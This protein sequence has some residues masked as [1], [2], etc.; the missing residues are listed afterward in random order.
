M[1]SRGPPPGLGTDLPWSVHPPGVSGDLQARRARRGPSDPY[2]V[3]GQAYLT[4]VGVPTL[5]QD[6]SPDQMSAMGSN[7]PPPGP[8]TG[9]LYSGRQVAEVEGATGL[10][11]KPRGG[12]KVPLTP[13]GNPNRRTHAGGVTSTRLISAPTW[14]TKC[15]NLDSVPGPEEVMSSRMMRKTAKMRR[16]SSD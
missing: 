6:W 11:G 9:L 2:L 10:R 1:G 16:K 15:T 14:P 8:G 3:S 4:L 12:G 13:P 5:C 7:E